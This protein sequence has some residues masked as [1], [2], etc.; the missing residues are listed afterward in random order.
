MR[1]GCENAQGVN[2]ITRKY[3][4]EDPSLSDYAILLQEG[5]GPLPDQTA[6]ATYQMAC[7]NGWMAGCG[8]L[9]YAYLVEEQPRDATRA[10]ALFDKACAGGNA[11]ACSNLGLMHN[12]GD[13]VPKDRA[14]ALG[15]LKQACDLGLPTACRVLAD[16]NTQK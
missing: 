5:K 10:R 3:R 1:A 7:D 13:G 9:G 11:Q 15:Y 4:R 2:P 12:N 16:E 8:R 14:R 6:L